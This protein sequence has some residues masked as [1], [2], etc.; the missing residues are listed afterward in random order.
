MVG[1]QRA[2]EKCAYT[3]YVAIIDFARPVRGLQNDFY[4]IFVWSGSVQDRAKQL[5]RSI[6]SGG[7]TMKRLGVLLVAVTV[8]AAIGAFAQ[9]AAREQPLTQNMG[10]IEARIATLEQ[11]VAVLESQNAEL[12]SVIQIS[13]AAGSMTINPRGQLML[14]GMSVVLESTN[15]AEIRAAGSMNLKAAGDMN[16]KG[17]LIRI[18]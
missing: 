5:I 2:S 18:N 16:L 10:S 4:Q 14:K 9:Y 13:T 8:S 12:R 15:H 1:R 11:K 7:T 17:S 6:H 3:T